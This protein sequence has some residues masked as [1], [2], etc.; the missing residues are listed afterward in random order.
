MK[1]DAAF[2]DRFAFLEWSIDE[3]LETAACPIGNGKYVQQ[4]RAGCR[5][6]R[7]GSD[8]LAAGLHIGTSLLAAGLD[9]RR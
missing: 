5:E 1:Q 7:K 3:A 9:R 2:V 8:R 6:W 4:V